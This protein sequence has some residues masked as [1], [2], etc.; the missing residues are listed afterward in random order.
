MKYFVYFPQ[1]A[2]NNMVKTCLKTEAA[3]IC[4]GEEEEENCRVWALDHF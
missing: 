3:Y 1:F 4:S 2:E